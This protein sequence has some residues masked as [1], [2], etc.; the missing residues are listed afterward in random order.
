VGGLASLKLWLS[1]F[2]LRKPDTTAINLPTCVILFVWRCGI[3]ITIKIMILC[4]R[5]ISINVLSTSLYS[6]VQRSCFYYENW[7]IFME[8]KY[9]W[10]NKRPRGRSWN[11]SQWKFILF[12]RLLP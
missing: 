3:Q 6:N 11:Y 8:L 4:T 9:K 1:L 5:L 2:W 10:H 7:I 12:A